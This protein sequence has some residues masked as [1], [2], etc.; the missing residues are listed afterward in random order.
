MLPLPPPGGNPPGIELLLKKVGSL[1][2]QISKW[3]GLQIAS[4]FPPIRILRMDPLF[5]PFVVKL[6]MVP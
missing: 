5:F 3:R 4:N 1:H 6:T 2:G